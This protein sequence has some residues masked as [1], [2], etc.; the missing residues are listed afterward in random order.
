MVP[1]EL[2]IWNAQDCA[3]YLKQS[4]QEF[5]RLTR[6]KPDFPQEL[7]NRPRHWNACRVQEWKPE[8]QKPR[9]LRP[10]CLYRHFNAAGELLYVGISLTATKRMSEHSRASKWFGEVANI[11]V[12]HYPDRES[13]LTAEAHA[14][15]TEKPKH[16]SKHNHG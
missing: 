13:A 2:T 14:I 4:R 5:L 8:P 6:H 16:N 7:Q 15:K 10:T 12:T 1:I 11:S 3:D 9:K